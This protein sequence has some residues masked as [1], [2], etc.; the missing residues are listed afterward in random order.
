MGKKAFVLFLILGLLLAGCSSKSAGSAAGNSDI[1]GALNL[2]LGSTDEPG[3][4]SSYHLELTL[5]TPQ[6]NDEGTAVVNQVTQIS[7]DV[8]GA[9]VLSS[10]L[11]RAR[12]ETKE[13]Y[14]IGE[15]EY[16]MVDG[17]KRK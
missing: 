14:I 4:F 16:K 2:V 12:R 11:T 15:T 17:Q 3:V 1:P 6:V 5:D 13:G 7:A 9:N 8:E 10:S